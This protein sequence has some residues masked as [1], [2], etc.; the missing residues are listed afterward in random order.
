M[1][2][3][4][5]HATTNIGMCNMANNRAACMGLLRQELVKLQPD[6]MLEWKQGC[7]AG[8]L[9]PECC[10]L[11]LIAAAQCFGLCFAGVLRGWL[12]FRFLCFTHFWA[13]S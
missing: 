10:T 11:L 6:S 7:P 2:I 1:I 13:S 9:L 3:P 4:Y 5:K 12:V 8:W